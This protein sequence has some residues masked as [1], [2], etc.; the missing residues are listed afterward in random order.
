[1]QPVHCRCCRC[2]RLPTTPYAGHLFFTRLRTHFPNS[3]HSK[4]LRQ[5]AA[6]FH[7]VVSPSSLPSGAFW[8][9]HLCVAA[10]SCCRL[11]TLPLAVDP[12]T[13]V[14]ASYAVYGTDPDS[15]WLISC[16]WSKREQ[17]DLVYDGGLEQLR[18]SPLNLPWSSLVSICLITSTLC[19]LLPPHILSIPSDK[20]E[21]RLLE[22]CRCSSLSFPASSLTVSGHSI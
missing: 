19:Q 13:S 8:C 17:H 20:S 3:S 6:S 10:F 11:L 2:N 1:M 4:T 21:L 22:Y 15:Q 18:S 9:L 5:S 7:P 14:V 16:S 12:S